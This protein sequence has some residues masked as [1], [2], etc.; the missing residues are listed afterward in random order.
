MKT[1]KIILLSICLILLLSSYC[2]AAE[3]KTTGTS[4]TGEN[5][6]STIG[7]TF[8]MADDWITTGQKNTKYTMSSKELSTMSGN[9]YNIL[10][11]VGTG[12]AVVV[13]AI[14]AIQ[15]MTS[16]L[17]RRAQVKEAIFPY[18]VSCIVIFGSLGIWKLSV[19]ILSEVDKNSRGSVST[20]MSQSK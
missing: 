2:L 9:L 18:I 5:S 1:I 6:K 4:G 15:Y 19:M 12:I 3:T 14:L 17:D 10:L 8:S 11:A 7:E 13:G 16:G 20:S